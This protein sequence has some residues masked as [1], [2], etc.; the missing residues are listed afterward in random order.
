M[1]GDVARPKRNS[2][3]SVTAHGRPLDALWLGGVN[4]CEWGEDR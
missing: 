3:W 2:Y 1:T 4:K